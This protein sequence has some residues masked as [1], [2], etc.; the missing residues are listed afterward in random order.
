[1]TAANKPEQAF[2]SQAAE[3]CRAREIGCVDMFSSQFGALR[4]EYMPSA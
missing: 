3:M 4:S 2:R 1:M